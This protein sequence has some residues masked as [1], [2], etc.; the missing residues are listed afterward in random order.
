[1]SPG[2]PARLIPEPVGFDD[3]VKREAARAERAWEAA[4]GILGFL[5]AG[6]GAGAA[7]GAAALTPVAPF[8]A[9]VAAGSLFFKLRAKWAR[10]DPPRWDFDLP[11]ESP[12]PAVDLIPVLPTDTMPR[13]AAFA[14]LLYSS[15]ASLEA[16][17][18]ATE[19]AMG[20]ELSARDL[21]A[22]PAR[23]LA[24]EHRT[25]A[26]RHARRTRWLTKGLHRSAGGFI[27]DADNLGLWSPPV[28][29]PFDLPSEGRLLSEVLEDWI[30]GH[31]IAA[32][33]D[34]RLLAIPV[35]AA[36]KGVEDPVGVLDEAVSAADALGQALL[37]WATDEELRR[38]PA[39]P[40]GAP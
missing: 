17:V 12:R 24:L 10:E 33:V 25:E 28:H 18:T 30:V 32:G 1:V 19:R 38:R 2:I 3:N 13:G 26:H 29:G 4:T 27:K 22:E 37:L 8:L 35:S 15:A 20:A 14:S 39:T 34:E 7:S 36:S 11:S 21:E 16:T 5:G 31:V 40:T 6:A 23:R 9:V